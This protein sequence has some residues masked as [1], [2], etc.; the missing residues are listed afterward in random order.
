MFIKRAFPIL[1]VIGWNRRHLVLLAI[2]NAI[3]IILFSIYGFHFLSLPWRPIALLGTVLGFFLGFKN[4]ICYSRIWEARKIWGGIV[5]ASRFWAIMVM[6]YIQNSKS[7][8]R[9]ISEAELRRIHLTLVNRHIAW[10]TAHRY[11]LRQ[12]KPWENAYSVRSNVRFM[13]NVPIDEWETPLMQELEKYLGDEEL[14]FLSKHRNIPNLLL[15]RQSRELKSL[16][17]R[18][19]LRH[20]CYLEMMKHLDQ[21]VQLQGK[22]ERIKGFPYPRQLATLNFWLQWIFIFL[23]PFGV[24]VP[25]YEMGATLSNHYA[26]LGEIGTITESIVHNFVWLSVPFCTLVAWVFNTI[27]RVG[28]VSENPFDGT[29]ND[30]PITSMSRNIERDLKELLDYPKEEIPDPIEP[31]EGILL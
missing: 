11:A 18:G 25:F 9:K 3:P 22:N 27:E 12:E 21:L 29:A 13:K 8:S 5:N 31:I 7:P 26:E 30:V 4:K 6:D 23:L 1:K 20:F 14:D 10:M 15:A 17:K 2:Y 24:M 19:L 16:E 28:E